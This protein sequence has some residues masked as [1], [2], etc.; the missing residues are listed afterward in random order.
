MVN[1]RKEAL[2]KLRK[3]HRIVLEGSNLEAVPELAPTWK[4]MVS[5]YG[6]GEAFLRGVKAGRYAKPTSV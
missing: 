6:F 3:K 2:I 4:R 5:K 1:K